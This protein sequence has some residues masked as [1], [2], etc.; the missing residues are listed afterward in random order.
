M[1]GGFFEY[2]G[3][4]HVHLE[5]VAELYGVRVVWLEELCERGFIGAPGRW[6]TLRAIAVWELDRV[7]TL[8]RLNVSLGVELET[9]ALLLPPLPHP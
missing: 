9:L 8:V 1:N 7:A 6:P 5:V 2:E 3:E 4:P